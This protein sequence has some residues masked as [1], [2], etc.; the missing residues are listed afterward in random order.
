[1]SPSLNPADSGTKVLGRR[2]FAYIAE[3]M[4]GHGTLVEVTRKVRT[5]ISDDFA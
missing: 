2:I 1:M 4:L 5:V 3:L